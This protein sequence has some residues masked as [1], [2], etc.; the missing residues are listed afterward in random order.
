MNKELIKELLNNLKEDNQKYTLN[1][2]ILIIDGLNTF[3]RSFAIIN[4]FNSNNNHIGGL[5][6]FLKSLGYIIKLINPTR[7]IVVFDGPGGSASK[8]NLYPEYKSNRHTGRVTNYHIFLNDKEGENESI[9]NQ[10]NRL[11]QFLHLLPI[12]LICIDALEADDI[13][14]YLV[15]KY[16]KNNE[17]SQITIMSADQDFL[18]L[19]SSKTQIYSPT[20]KKFY[21]TPQVLDEY[22]IHPNNFIIMKSLMGDKS[23]NLPGI[24][25]LGPKKF[26]KLFTEYLKTELKFS[27]EQVLEL[28]TINIEFNKLYGKVLERKNQ[29][30]INYKLMDLKNIPLS[31]ENINIIEDMLSKE[32]KFDKQNFYLMYNNDNLGESIPNCYNWLLQIFTPLQTYRII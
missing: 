20:K 10:M 9:S 32:V 17:T 7:V 25:G 18:Q 30:E 4:Q 23:D 16:E 27:L 19:V 5:V 14:G 26:K 11:L 13:M 28:A 31:P 29:L 12:D 24:D 3:L 21:Q 15:S 1:N 22:G 6:G 2:K 8:K